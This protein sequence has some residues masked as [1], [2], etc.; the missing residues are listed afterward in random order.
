[1]TIVAAVLFLIWNDPP[2]ILLGGLLV[3]GLAMIAY[4]L[5]P[6]AA[7]FV[8][9][10]VSVKARTSRDGQWAWLVVQNGA[11]TDQFDVEIE[12]LDTGRD[13]HPYHAPWRDRSRTMTIA[14]GGS[15]TI[16]V[17]S[18]NL[19]DMNALMRQAVRG[20][21]TLVFHT[22]ENPGGVWTMGQLPVGTEMRCRGKVLRANG[23]PLPPFECLLEI[24]TPSRL[25]F[26]RIGRVH[27]DD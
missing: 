27:R 12:W 22:T 2:K 14:K 9:K 13:E 15:G 3:I 18:V 16:N 26:T 25:R 19:T 6:T 7:F 4:W 10:K 8:A 17:A 1:M 21:A 23:A 24:V 11:P 20:E 5:V